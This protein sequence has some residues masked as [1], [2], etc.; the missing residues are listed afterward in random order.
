MAEFDFWGWVLYVALWP[1]VVA[2]FGWGIYTLRLRYR[3]HEDISPWVETLTLMLVGV[4]YIAELFLLRRYLAHTPT[5]FV[6]ALLGLLVSGAALYGPMAVSLVS[7]LVVDVMLPAERSKT[8]EPRYAPAEALERAG[9]FEGALQEYI[10]IARVFPRDAA[11]L[12]R[13]GNLHARLGKP[14]DAVAWFERALTCVESAEK[15]LQ[16]AN[17]L[18][19]LYNRDLGRPD[20]AVRVL[21]TYLARFPAAEHADSVR[22]RLERLKNPA[23]NGSASG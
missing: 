21:Q 13:I 15:N 18:C 4:F 16:I 20:D 23:L 6:F 8:R 7:R 1:V 11:V 10:V 14:Q 17:R 5:H 19:A 2:Y 12:V 9:D 3:F 22:D